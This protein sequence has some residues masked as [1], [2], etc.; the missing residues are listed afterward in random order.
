MQRL[1]NVITAS[2][3][4]YCEEAG[5]VKIKITS[6]ELAKRFYD[7]MVNVCGVQST[8]NLLSPTVL[9]LKLD[10]DGSINNPTAGI[11]PINLNS[12][13]SLSLDFERHSMTSV[14]SQGEVKDVNMKIVRLG[15]LSLDDFEFIKQCHIVRLEIQHTPQQADE[16]RLVSILQHIRKL[17]EL[18]IKCLDE[19]S[20]SIIDLVIS[21]REKVF[22]SGES[23]ALTTFKLMEYG[24][25]YI[26][27]ASG[28]GALVKTFNV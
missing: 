1:K 26:K 4:S 12:F 5:E 16:D 6:D 9:E 28:K 3:G 14:I 7:G 2:G 24:K 19:R 15:D 23:L 22:Q 21:T 20:L 25:T 27:C 8:S 10:C 11:V 18:H 17:K 13:N